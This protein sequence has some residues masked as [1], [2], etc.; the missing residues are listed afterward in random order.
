MACAA[1]IDLEDCATCRMGQPAFPPCLV[2][3]FWEL[4]IRP[5][6]DVVQCADKDMCLVQPGVDGAVHTELCG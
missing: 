3:V 5:S 1:S 6:R 2:S 4:F